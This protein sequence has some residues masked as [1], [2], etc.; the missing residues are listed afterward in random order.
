MVKFSNKFRSDQAE[1]MDDVQFGG[2]E[3][4]RLLDDLKKINKWLGGNNI[5]INGI[6]KLLG[7]YPKDKPLVILDIGCGDGALLRK[8][9]DFAKKNQIELRGIG[10]DFNTNILKVAK[11]Q[12][13]DYP[14]I[15]FL[16]VDVFSDNYIIPECD[17]ALYTLFLHHFDDEEVVDLVNMVLKK[18]RL[19]C[20]INDLHRS[21]IAF[22]LFKFISFF[23][24][25]SD[26]AKHDGLVS[27]A[28]G[29]K[30]K[31]LIDISRAI[32]YQKSVI[33]WRW[34]FRYQ[35]ILKKTV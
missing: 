23:F 6:Q 18:T 7:Q 3:M 20:V 27:I 25:K 15:K 34:A 11:E 14:N 12:S 10:L 28:K 19:G 31:E 35:W 4:R 32:P 13:R 9:A 21:R 24:I 1:I 2:P 16:N 8:C 29:F 26:T 22:I 30:K 33:L 5:T 17:I